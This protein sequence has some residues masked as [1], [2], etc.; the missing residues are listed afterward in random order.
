M[1]QKQAFAS[2]GNE[3]ARQFLVWLFL[4]GV[5]GFEPA[6]SCSQSRRDNRATL[7]PE[8]YLFLFSS[9]PQL[10]EISN[11][12]LQ[13]P[14]FWAEFIPHEFIRTTAGLH[15]ETAYAVISFMI[16]RTWRT[17]PP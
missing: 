9:F 3:K 11:L 16:K 13:V 5:A 7:H 12:T 1:L 2:F 10:T 17:C 14:R 6:T 4:V 15:P 8:E